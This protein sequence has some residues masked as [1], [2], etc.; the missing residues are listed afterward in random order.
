[1]CFDKK[2]NGEH[3]DVVYHRHMCCN[4]HDLGL[5][6]PED[7]LDYQS[8]EVIKTAGAVFNDIGEELTA[9]EINT[10]SLISPVSEVLVEVRLII[11]KCGC[12]NVDQLSTSE[13]EVMGRKGG[14]WEDSGDIVA[15]VYDSAMGGC[16]HS[17]QQLDSSKIQ[18]EVS[19]KLEDL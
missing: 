13:F 11:T 12:A 17:S 18:L 15:V 8:L 5:I 2:T 1:M 9:R 4:I 3:G 14:D 10:D 6:N 19:V 16:R 7:C